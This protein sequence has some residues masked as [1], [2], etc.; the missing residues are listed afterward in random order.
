MIISALHIV[1]EQ[2]AN[3]HISKLN[4]ALEK[5]DVFLTECN[6]STLELDCLRHK[7]ATSEQPCLA[8]ISPTINN[9]IQVAKQ[10]RSLLSDIDFIFLVEGSSQEL[11]TELQSPTSVLGSHWEVKDIHSE[12][13][14]HQLSTSLKAVHK[15]RKFRTTLT[16]LQN[17]LK[18]TS[19]PKVSELQKYTVSL[20]HLSHIVE[21]AHDA[22]IAT[23]SDGI[24]VKWNQASQKIFHMS[25]DEAVGTSIFEIYDHDWGR[26]L[27]TDYHSLFN[28]DHGFIE[29]EISITRAV[30]LQEN[31]YNI[32]LSVI[33][34]NNGEDIGVSAVMRDITEKKATEN[35]L[36]EIRKDLEKMSY[37]DGLTSVA[38]RRMF[39]K[40]LRNEWGR[41]LR[42]QSPLSIIMFDIDYFKHYNDTYGHQEGDKCLK[43]V[44]EI[45]KNEIKRSSDLIARYGGEEFILLLPGTNE[46]DAKSLA[47]KCCTAV[48]KANIPHDSSEISNTVTVSGGV[49]S[50]IPIQ[51]SKPEAIIKM[52]DNMLYIAKKNGRNQVQPT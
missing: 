26:R 32:I 41:L 8:F 42:T 35:I 18:A 9:P 48:R 2:G 6:I 52:A 45:L 33:R 50:L 17:K 10:I 38:N 12:G 28:S 43:K 14:I 39:D 51:T 20:Q 49:G 44:A 46:E 30:D 24:I 34:D 15:R 21:H 40:A 25:S 23:T 16:H 47:L 11:L 4:Q 13:F 37:E 27:Q 22:I 1:N 31:Y 7:N 19:K 3:A 29:H 5:I 36:A